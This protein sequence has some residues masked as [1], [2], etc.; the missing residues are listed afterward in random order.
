MCMSE[1][2]EE[3]STRVCLLKEMLPAVMA[4]LH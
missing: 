4:L 3:Q 2:T 1:K